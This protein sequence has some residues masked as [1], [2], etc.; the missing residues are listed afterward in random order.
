MRV[1]DKEGRRKKRRSFRS[2]TCRQAAAHAVFGGHDDGPGHRPLQLK[3]RFNGGYAMLP[4]EL[5]SGLI[6]DVIAVVKLYHRVSDHG[7]RHGLSC[8]PLI[9]L[10]TNSF[11]FGDEFAA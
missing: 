7:V 6:A 8:E 5:A 9:G 10:I 11:Q 3:G 2:E 1:F 4:V